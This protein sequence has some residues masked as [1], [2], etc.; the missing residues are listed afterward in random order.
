MAA[1]RVM[2]LC[3]VEAED[4]LEAT[5]AAIEM[6]QEGAYTGSWINLEN[7]PLPGLSS[8]LMGKMTDDWSI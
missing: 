4:E 8:V 3:E 7:E 5:D 6:V 1:Y 2:F